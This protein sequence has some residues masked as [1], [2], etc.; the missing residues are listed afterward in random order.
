MEGL[1][2]A[3]GSD[4]ASGSDMSSLE[5]DSDEELDSDSDDDAA[6][7]APVKEVDVEAE[8]A[9]RIRVQQKRKAA[10]DA[11]LSAER[12]KRRLPVRAAEGWQSASDVSGDE[13]ESTISSDDADAAAKSRAVHA[14]LEDDEESTSSEDEEAKRRA[15]QPTS[16]IT[17][18][19]RFGMLAPYAILGLPKRSERVAAAREQIA[20]L[21]TDIVG[22]PE[23]SLGMLRR[24]AVFA[25]R[26]VSA[27][28]D[29]RPAGD[30]K[31]PKRQVDDAIRAAAI[32]SMCAVFVDILPGYRIRAL[33]DAEQKEKTN[34]ETAR[35][36]EWEQG[37]V[38]TYRS[39]LDICDKILRGELRRLPGVRMTFTRPPTVKIPLSAVA[40]RSMCLLLTRA[41]HFNYRTNLIRA[42]VSQLSRRGW[43]EDSAACASAL[44]EV[45]RADLRGDV[46]LEVV[47]L[48]NRMI[49]E[50][51]YRVNARVLD[52]LLHLRLRDELGG[53]RGDMRFVDRKDPR[54]VAN[55]DAR[56][57]KRAKIGKGKATPKEVRKGL[58]KHLSKK[59]VKSMRE[60]KE[61][62]A[63]LR[64][65][66]AE[67]DVEERTRN[68][69]GA[70]VADR[71]ITD[72]SW[73]ANRDS[74]AALRPVLLHPQGHLSAWPATRVCTRGPGALCTPHQRGFLPRSACRSAHA[75]RRGAGS[76]GDAVSRLA[77]RR[78]AA[79]RQRRRRR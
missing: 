13:D 17:T 30:G 45:L 53:R 12:A 58:G 49:K 4:V 73:S 42:L 9:A 74:Q 7:R 2:I 23:V 69:S 68:V 33:T 65:A 19:A 26:A 70:C 56:T 44:T 29:Q 40:L 24:L 51:G 38:D 10:S 27:P 57:P 6:P 54:D 60:R 5:F 52:L 62:E 77:R 11:A 28:E 1:S 75:R 61:I 48:L 67:V 35:R 3:S 36:R 63:E 15:A 32:M 59:E 66:D 76:S 21:S 79:Q 46:S 22:D 78:R 8:H 43:S 25:G 37:L 20:R 71:A 50:R 34:Q 64:E 14:P 72:T 31:V 16:T 41:T 18:G 47:R 39:F 55:E